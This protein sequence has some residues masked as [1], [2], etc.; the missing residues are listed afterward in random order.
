MIC[1]L[2]RNVDLSSG[3]RERKVETTETVGLICRWRMLYI[4]IMFTKPVLRS[5]KKPE[6]TNMLMGF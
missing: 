1:D 4:V 2:E 5:A 3:E 6:K